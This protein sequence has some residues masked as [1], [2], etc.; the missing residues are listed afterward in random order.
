[1]KQL[2][3]IVTLLLVCSIS[4]FIA[5]KGP[6]GSEGPQ[7]PEGPE[8]PVGP[9]GEDGSQI[10]AGTGAPSVDLGSE[11]DYYLD[12]NTGDLYG[13]KN[14]QGWGTPISLQGPP[15]DDGEDGQDGEDGSQIYS[16]TGAPAASLGV[17]GD[18]YLDKSSYELYGPKSSSGWETPISLKGTANVLYSSWVDISWDGG[19]A[20]SRYMRISESRVTEEFLNSGAIQMYMKSS[21]S[22]GFSITPL[23]FTDGDHELYFSA[24]V[25]TDPQN[26][27]NGIILQLDHTSG[28]PLEQSAIDYFADQQV[29]YVLI[30]GGVSLSKESKNIPIDL[31]DYEQ[32]KEYYGIQE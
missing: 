22:S 15:G 8:G 9:A 19:G 3:Q 20:Y 4:I 27:F 21:G 13:P 16:G 14:D 12:Q 26:L 11:G 6:S 10:H 17:E 2:S 7:G 31:D 23:S 32:V 28:Q 25:S 30:P 29:R 24:G 5:C 18:Y 1:M